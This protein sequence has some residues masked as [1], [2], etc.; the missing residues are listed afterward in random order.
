[1]IRTGMLSFFS[2]NRAAH[3]FL[4]VLFLWSL[5]P[6]QTPGGN[7]GFG[8]TEQREYFAQG[9]GC[10]LPVVVDNRG[11]HSADQQLSI[12]ARTPQDAL[13]AFERTIS[14]DRATAIRAFTP[15][16]AH[17]IYTQH[18]SSDW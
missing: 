17:I 13:K 4:G 12:F 8:G 7:P 18:T 9:Q 1:M 2:R 10:S 15:L 11:K 3:L 6:L 5:L 16:P 14:A